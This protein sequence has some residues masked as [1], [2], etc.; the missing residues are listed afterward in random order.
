[1]TFEETA[2]KQIARCSR[3]TPRVAN[4]ILRR[5][6][7]FALIEKRKT[8]KLTDVNNAL[9]LMEIDSLGLDRMDRKILQ[10]IT[11][12][13]SGGPVGIETLCATLNE[14]RGTI[15]DVYEPYLLKE[16]FL[17]R[18]SRGRECSDKSKE[19]LTNI[20]NLFE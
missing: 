5:E 16:G 2:L 17:L 19:H 10:V 15:E 8:I 14:D 11:D 18:T 1:M 20:S 7:D 4:R 6:R 13:Y 9:G 12:Y 3:G